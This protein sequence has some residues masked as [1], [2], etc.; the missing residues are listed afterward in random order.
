M[1]LYKSFNDFEQIKEFYHDLKIAVDIVEDLNLNTQI[2][3]K[4]DRNN[5][6]LYLE[7]FDYNYR[8]RWLYILLSYIFGYLGLHY[9]YIGF[10]G[11]GLKNLLITLAVF[12][13]LIYKTFICHDI[14]SGILLAF[15]AFIWLLWIVIT[16]SWLEDDS[17][18]FPLD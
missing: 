7:P 10:I 4:D 9:F 18:G 1:N 11:K 14:S 15:S 13:F 17:K 12:P 16:A 8:K 2:W 3:L 6:D 5:P